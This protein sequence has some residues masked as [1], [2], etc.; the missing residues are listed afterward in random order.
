MLI[1]KKLAIA[2]LKGYL[3]NTISK[4]EVYKWASAIVVSSKFDNLDKSDKLLSDAI[5]AMFEL[6]HEDGKFDPSREELEKYLEALELED[7][8][9]QGK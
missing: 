3:N 1:D 4:K 9:D 7:F 8:L 2:K 5:Q 6:H